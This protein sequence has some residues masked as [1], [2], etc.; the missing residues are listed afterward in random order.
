MIE[1]EVT[2]NQEFNGMVL[3]YKRLRSWV[4]ISDKRL[5]TSWNLKKKKQLAVIITDYLFIIS[6]ATGPK[7][8]LNIF[9]HSALTNA[10]YY[11]HFRS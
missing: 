7:N 3:G 6:V 8:V 1:G 9:F 11:E 5:Q 10:S 4:Y 2:P